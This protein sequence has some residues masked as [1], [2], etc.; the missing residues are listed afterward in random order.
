MKTEID[1]K[2]RGGKK[3]SSSKRE[4]AREGLA[5]SGARTPPPG[6]QVN[7]ESQE[8]SS[9]QP[10]VDPRYHPEMPLAPGLGWLVLME[11]VV[12]GPGPP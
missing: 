6:N 9:F 11:G 10:V 12:K 4:D 1:R 7:R 3:W 2:G 8:G 5:A